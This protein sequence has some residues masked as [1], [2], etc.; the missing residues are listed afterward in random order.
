MERGHRSAC[1]CNGTRKSKAVERG[2]RLAAPCSRTTV[3][4]GCHESCWKH[5]LG[6]AV[7]TSDQRALRDA[8][9]RLSDPDVSASYSES[10]ARFTAAYS[11]D[12]FRTALL[13]G[14]DIEERPLEVRQQARS[15]G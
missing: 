7:D 15:V 9:V 2:H 14:L 1:S 12:R 6:L 13:H 4:P 5:A 10:L 3:P 8:I 11:A